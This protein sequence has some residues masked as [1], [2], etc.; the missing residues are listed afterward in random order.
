MRL[1]S[2]LWRELLGRRAAQWWGA[3]GAHARQLV[4]CE[5]HRWKQRRPTATPW[6]AGVRTQGNHHIQG[7]K[8]RGS[9]RPAAEGMSVGCQY[10]LIL[11]KSRAFMQRNSCGVI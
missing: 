11:K 10:S 1:R 4:V 2:T 9:W 5:Q 6:E 8:A 3:W 7:G